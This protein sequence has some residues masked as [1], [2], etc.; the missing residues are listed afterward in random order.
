MPARPTARDFITFQPNADRWWAVAGVVLWIGVFLGV[1]AYSYSSVHKAEATGDSIKHTVSTVYW[2]AAKQWWGQ[3]DMY[4]SKEPT[5]EGRHGFLYFP[6]A[7]VLFSPLAYLPVLGAEVLWRLL[8]LSMAAWAL[9]RMCKV[10]GDR[11]RLWFGLGS[12][13]AMPAVS[14]SAQNGQCN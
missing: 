6:Q 10:F 12:L 14:L 2:T 1:A 5:Q 3:Q 4:G 8:N 13:I 7:A 9:W 11:P